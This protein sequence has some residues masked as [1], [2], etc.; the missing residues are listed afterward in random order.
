MC[1][2]GPCLSAECSFSEQALFEMF[3]DTKRTYITMAKRKRTYITMTKRKMTYITMAK[4]K[5]T[6]ITMTK[7]EGT[8]ITM[9]KREGTKGQRMIYETLHRKQD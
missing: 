4:R 9:A 3:E 5:R 7:R 8:Y 2:T 6:Y 1:T